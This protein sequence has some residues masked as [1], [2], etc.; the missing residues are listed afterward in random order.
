MISL[1]RFIWSPCGRLP[2]SDK[3]SLSTKQYFLVHDRLTSLQSSSLKHCLLNTKPVWKFSVR[4]INILRQ[5]LLAFFLGYII[6]YSLLLTSRLKS[7]FRAIN[8]PSCTKTV[9][10]LERWLVDGS[11]LTFLL[12]PS[13]NFEAECKLGVN[14]LIKT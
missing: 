6:P 10:Q 5:K 2:L 4:R 7:Y 14:T 12:T 13:P 1:R 11:Y 9:I 3:V 8:L